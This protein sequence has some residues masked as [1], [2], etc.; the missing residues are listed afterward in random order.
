MGFYQYVLINFGKDII[1]GINELFGIDGEMIYMDLFVEDL[2]YLELICK[3]VLVDVIFEKVWDGVWL[4]NV[5]Y[6]W[7]YS[8]G[9]NEGY[10]CLDNGQDDVGLMILFD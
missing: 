2:G 5:V 9:N 6:I 3:Y 10:V 1:V 7:L 8:W 4:L